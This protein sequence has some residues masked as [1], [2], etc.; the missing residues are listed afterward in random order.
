[1][2]VSVQSKDM[3]RAL[4]CCYA[5]FTLQIEYGGVSAQV[6][7]AALKTV[8]RVSSPWGIVTATPPPNYC[9]VCP[10]FCRHVWAIDKFDRTSDN[11]GATPATTAK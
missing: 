3:P 11:V 2:L 10:T 8:A 4:I 6:C 1:M 7:R 5:A 9:C